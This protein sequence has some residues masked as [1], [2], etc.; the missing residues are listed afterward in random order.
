MTR[1]GSRSLKQLRRGNKES[2]LGLFMNGGELSRVR[3]AAATGLT[4]A[5]VTQ[6]VRELI[7]EGLLVEGDEVATGGAGRRETLLRFAGESVAAVGVNIERDRTHVSLCSWQEV[8]E[9]EIYP[10]KDLFAAGIDELAERISELA[11]KSSWRRFLGTGLAVAGQVDEVSGRTAGDY[12][13][14]VPGLPLAGEI[15]RLTGRETLLVN[16]VRAQARA[17]MSD[18]SDSFMLVK[19][20]PGVGC[21]VI[22]E[23][24]V[25]AGANGRAGELGHTVV[26]GE[27]GICRCGRRG[28]LETCVSESRISELYET[29]TGD[30]VPAQEIY[31]R[32]PSDEAAR[33]IVDGCLSKLAVAVGNAALVLNPRK[34][35]VT[36][37]IFAREEIFEAFAGAVRAAGFGGE[38]PLARI[39][40]E[41]R[42]KA[43]SGAR[44]VM[45]KKLFGM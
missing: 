29:K 5:S 19:H 11:A 35:L 23:G 16:N 43:F 31:A 6:L 34:V 10:T 13:L 3:I 12:G 45:L 14:F 20:G 24:V 33:E 38:F 17:L 37:G 4:S 32:Y 18:P 26:P 2:V 44:H 40:D 36:G 25:V 1:Q 28:C 8:L 21:A 42:V 7:G 30:K 39:G 41:R 22:S 9:E 15:A 27:R